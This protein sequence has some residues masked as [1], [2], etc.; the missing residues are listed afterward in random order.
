MNGWRAI[1]TTP[2]ITELELLWT[3]EIR[4]YERLGPWTKEALIILSC[5]EFEPIEQ[6]MKDLFPAHYSGVQR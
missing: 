4:D 1:R 2:V 5:A 6:A 3:H